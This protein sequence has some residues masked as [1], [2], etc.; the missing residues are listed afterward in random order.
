MESNVMEIITKIKED[1]HN[2]V[3]T[4]LSEYDLDDLTIEQYSRIRL[5]VHLE[6]VKSM[7]KFR[8]EMRELKS[9]DISILDQNFFIL[10][11][12]LLLKLSSRYEVIYFRSNIY[13]N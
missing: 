3:E 1:A 7:L 2:N 9:I 11:E 10:R 5:R 13:N 4:I 6:L 12:S 8:N